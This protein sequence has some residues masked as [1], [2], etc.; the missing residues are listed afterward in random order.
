[1]KLYF[2]IIFIALNSAFGF[3]QTAE[4]DFLGNTTIKWDKTPEGEILKHYFV[5]INTGDVPLVIDDAEVACSCTKVDFPK[6]PIAPKSK[7][8]ILVAFNTEGKFYNQDRKIILK[9][10]TKK[11][12][13]LRLKVYVIPKDEK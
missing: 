10:N 2:A 12:E 9:A 6:K 13:K 3:G 5:F 11:Q 1:M 7:D 4:F 8:S